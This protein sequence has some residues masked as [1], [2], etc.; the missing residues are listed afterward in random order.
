MVDLHQHKDEA[1]R[2]S[3]ADL[4]LGFPP[5]EVRAWLESSRF[6]VMGAEVVGDSDTIQFITFQGL[7]K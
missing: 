5:A 1:F 7:K 6:E 4:W 2:E 3:M